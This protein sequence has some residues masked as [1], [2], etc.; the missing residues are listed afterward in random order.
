MFTQLLASALLSH[1][2]PLLGIA[3]V[4]Y[5]A[6]FIRLSKSADQPHSFAPKFAHPANTFRGVSQRIGFFVAFAML[7]LVTHLGMERLSD[8]LSPY[9]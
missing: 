6:F 2:P 1:V 4:Y 5:V 3:F 7:V 8:I 9:K